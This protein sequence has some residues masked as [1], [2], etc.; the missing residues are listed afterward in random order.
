MTILCGI[1]NPTCTVLRPASAEKESYLEDI[2]PEEDSS[3]EERVAAEQSQIK[4][5][6]YD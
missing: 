6:T 5:I 4:P 2:M 1:P 3:P